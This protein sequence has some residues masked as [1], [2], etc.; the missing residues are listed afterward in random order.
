[1]NDVTRKRKSKL[2]SNR[3][4]GMIQSVVMK[5]KIGVEKARARTIMH[6]DEQDEGYKW[7]TSE[8]VEQRD[9]GISMLYHRD[10][11]RSI[12]RRSNDRKDHYRSKSDSNGNESPQKRQREVNRTEQNVEMSEIKKSTQTTIKDGPPTATEPKEGKLEIVIRPKR[13]AILGQP[14]NLKRLQRDDGKNFYTLNNQ[15]ERRHQ[16]ISA[17]HIALGRT[18]R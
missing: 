16:H 2:S 6:R 8:T 12:I 10:R 11:S 17:L 5:K 14:N 1:M 3:S 4:Q 18:T 9:C 15:I 13:I 7:A